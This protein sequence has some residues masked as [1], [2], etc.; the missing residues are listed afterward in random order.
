MQLGFCHFSS[1]AL[2]C[3]L[4]FEYPC[5]NSKQFIIVRITG[6]YIQNVAMI[7]SSQKIWIYLQSI[8]DTVM[9]Y[10]SQNSDIVA[11]DSHE[12]KFLWLNKATSDVNPMSGFNSGSQPQEEWTASIIKNNNNM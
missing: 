7:L 10:I 1:I 12:P 3:T 11:V 5:T 8:P 2:F 6:V 9:T 4:P